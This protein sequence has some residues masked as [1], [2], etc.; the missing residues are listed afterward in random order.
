MGLCVFS[1]PI[2]LVMIDRTFILSLIIIIKSEVWTITHCLGLCHEEII[3]AVCLSI[4]YWLLA[5]WDQAIIWSS[6]DLSSRKA[7]GIYSRLNFARIPKL[8]ISKFVLKYAHLKSQPHLF[9]D[10]ELIDSLADHVFYTHIRHGPNVLCMPL[11]LW[12]EQQSL[13]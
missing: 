2:S 1:L 9:K 11:T 7:S 13:C 4:F 12:T 5:R 6:E 8:S 10:G 3:C